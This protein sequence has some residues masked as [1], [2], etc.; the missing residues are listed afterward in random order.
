MYDSFSEGKMHYGLAFGIIGVAV[1]LASA[2]SF[3]I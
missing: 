1:V 2:I 3:L